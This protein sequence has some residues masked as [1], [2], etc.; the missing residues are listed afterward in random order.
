VTSKG[1][2]RRWRSR[3][4]TASA[5]C[6]FEHTCCRR[7]LPQSW[8]MANRLLKLALPWSL[9]CSPGWAARLPVPPVPPTSPSP[10]RVVQVPHRGS[11]SSTKATLSRR[12]PIPPIP[13]ASAPLTRPA[14]VPDRDAQPP[15]EPNSSPHT[16]VSVT[17]FR[18]PQVDTSAGFLYGSRFQ[19][20]EDQRPIQTPGFT[21]IFPLRLP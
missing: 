3:A 13:H 12:T 21:V 15:P 14:P 16:K 4:A 17:D 10:V 6:V 7:P 11:H 18:P 1:R 19:S 2:G 5:G 20:A 9:I 8:V